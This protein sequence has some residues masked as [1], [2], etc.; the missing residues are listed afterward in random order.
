M[1]RFKCKKNVKILN[2]SKLDSYELN[3]KTINLIDVQYKPL[4]AFD[5]ITS[6]SNTY[7]HKSF[8]LA[9]SI[10]KKGKIKKFINGPISKKKFLGKKYLG[11]TE[12][13]S[14]K[15]S[16]KKTCMLIYNKELS[17]CPITTHVPIK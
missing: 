7:I 1:K 10:L 13:I 3:N 6:K 5:K 11:I 17:V 4:K 8:D 15:F 9:F 14:S 16:K 12:L 2:S